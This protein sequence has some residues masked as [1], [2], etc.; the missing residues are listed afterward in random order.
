LADHL[1]DVEAALQ[2]LVLLLLKLGLTAV[3][4]I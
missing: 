2:E 3:R 1:A 4:P